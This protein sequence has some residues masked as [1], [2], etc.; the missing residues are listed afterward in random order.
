M[1]RRAV[2]A[3]NLALAAKVDGRSP[4]AHALT[5]EPELGAL[6]Q[7]LPLDLSLPALAERP[8]ELARALRRHRIEAPV[9]E[10]ALLSYRPRRRAVLRHGD[11]VL[12]TYSS[13]ADFHRAFLGLR[14]SS[15]L[16]SLPTACLE[17]AL[18]DLRLTSQTLLRGSPPSHAPA[19]VRE[20]AQVVRELHGSGLEG[21]PARP[22]HAQLRAAA[23]SAALA[24]AL[25]P[26]IGPRLE[27]L[28]SL[29]ES[30]MPETRALVPSHGD[31]HARQVMRDDGE[32][33]LID[34][35]EMCAAP[36]AFDLAN[37]AAHFI[38]GA[39]GE[40]ALARSAL[41]DLVDGYGERPPDLDWYFAS[42][43]L[44][45]TPFPFRYLDD[46]WPERV[47]AMTAAAESALVA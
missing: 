41:I 18:P 25:V 26:E 22:P 7:W 30:S 2:K 20:T 17:A 27:R 1:R 28:M 31:F 3:E 8:Q 46:H 43:I 42:C 14:M 47:R 10:P 40:V 5:Y 45:R 36:P 33:A 19:I 13:E 37:Y 21:L 32:L 39:D 24:T 15:G 12:K 6:L 11:H 16:S 38:R 23:A 9:G 29:L 35:D 4:V 34:F 44:R